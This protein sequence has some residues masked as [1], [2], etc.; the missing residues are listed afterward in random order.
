MGSML[1]PPRLRQGKPTRLC[2]SPPS[3]ARLAHTHSQKV[4]RRDPA[5]LR[6]L[7]SKTIIIQQEHDGKLKPV[8]FAF[9]APVVVVLVALSSSILN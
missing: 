8:K 1:A 6:E 9:I 4:Y 3:Y 7:R 5:R 2:Q